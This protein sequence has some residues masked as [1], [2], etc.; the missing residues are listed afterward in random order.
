MTDTVLDADRIV[1]A[2]QRTSLLS[3]NLQTDR[4]TPPAVSPAKAKHRALPTGVKV[5]RSTEPR[6]GGIRK[7]T[8]N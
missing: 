5:D 6:S 8:V 7:A 4:H 2:R 1:A 3:L